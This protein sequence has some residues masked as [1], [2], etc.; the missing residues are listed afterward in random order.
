MMRCKQKRYNFKPLI[1][2]EPLNLFAIKPNPRIFLAEDDVDDQELLDDALT[3]IDP[4][5]NLISFTSGRKFIEAL[6]KTE[7]ADLP[8]LIILDYNIP[9]INGAEI[10][11]HLNENSRYGTITKIIWSTSNS[12]KFRTSCLQLGAKDYIIKPASISGIHQLAELFLSL[13]HSE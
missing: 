11:Q 2:F 10:L 5:V 4:A 7:D 1:Y 3:A 13:C 6:D 9:E 12:E 8:C